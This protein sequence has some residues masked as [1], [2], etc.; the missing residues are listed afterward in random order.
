MTESVGSDLPDHVDERIIALLKLDG[1]ASYQHLGVEL[2]I[3]KSTARSRVRRLSE[4]GIIK[5]VGVVHPELLGMTHA[6]RLSVDTDGPAWPVAER[7]AATIGA[8]V[9]V[10]LSTGEFPVVAE[11]RCG[12][13]GDLEKAIWALR[14]VPGVRGARTALYSRVHRDPNSRWQPLEA[15]DIDRHD[16]AIMSRLQSD[17]RLSFAE[18]AEGVGLSPAAVRARTLK[19]IDSGACAVRTLTPGI[20]ATARMGGF[21]V[22]VAD[23]ELFDVA[24][25]LDLPEISFVASALGWADL[26]GTIEAPDFHHVSRVTDQL[27]AL[28]GVGCVHSWIHYA[29]VKENYSGP[30]NPAD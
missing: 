9:Y 16:R 10:T 13:P 8:A 14:A 24:R 26:F 6:A 1:R 5:I 30:L 27:R 19:L 15:V 23:Q 20:R 21:A 12:S 17:G 25:V 2:G 22:I 18:L 7:I 29:V 3:S 28:P 11:L 4:A